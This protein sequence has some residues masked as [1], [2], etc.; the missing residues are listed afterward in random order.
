[1]WKISLEEQM[2]S[3]DKGN[4]CRE[5]SGICRA[6]ARVTPPPNPPSLEYAE[7]SC[8]DSEHSCKTLQLSN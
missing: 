5:I 1:M 2:E 4:K 3:R 6:R 8:P 7:M